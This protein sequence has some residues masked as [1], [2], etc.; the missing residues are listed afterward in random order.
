MLDDPDHD[1]DAR[2][3][4]DRPRRA[5]CSLHD[6][7]A[8]TPADAP[9]REVLVALAEAEASPLRGLGALLG[10]R[11]G[12]GGAVIQHGDRVL[13][14]LRGQENPAHDGP[15]WAQ[16]GDWTRPTTEEQIAISRAKDRA[17][18][19]P[20]DAEAVK[21][22]PAAYVWR[23]R[24]LAAPDAVTRYT[25]GWWRD[26]IALAKDAHDDRRRF[27]TL[28]GAPLGGDPEFEE[29][30]AGDVAATP[31]VLADVQRMLED[32]APEGHEVDRVEA[33]P[34]PKAGD[35]W[36]ICGTTSTIHH[37]GIERGRAVAFWDAEGVNYTALDVLARNGRLESAKP[38][39][40]VCR[41]LSIS[42]L[43]PQCQRE[44]VA[45]MSRNEDA[46]EPPPTV[47]R[48]ARQEPETTLAALAH[49]DRV[50]L[51]RGQEPT[52]G[53]RMAWVAAEGAPTARTMLA[54]GFTTDELLEAIR[55]GALLSE[56]GDDDAE[57]PSK[58][59][60][61]RIAVAA[62]IA[63]RYGGIEEAH[64][65]QWVIDQML[66]AMLGEDAY[67]AWVAVQNADRNYDP[68]D[69]GITP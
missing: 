29:L 41:H 48:P 69:V 38:L 39:P 50:R 10:M 15:W 7:L 13:V 27:V 3:N 68:W 33:E 40:T 47:P 2:A 36:T 31:E 61:R 55:S 14:T 49:L 54:L 67:R 57:L 62:D 1:H 6:P 51:R 37:V 32:T 35:R 20:E 43:C 42:G 23:V 44:A 46:A 60:A 53:P 58:I 45:A 18:A 63:H 11:R 59:Q 19:D 8:I 52:A 30:A 66:R 12:E 65:K 25:L 9:R 24:D 56:V 4:G 22:P 17:E 34:S 5:D 28:E 21:P 16:D 26:L 64:H